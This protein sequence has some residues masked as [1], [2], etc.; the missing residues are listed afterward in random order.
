METVSGSQE[1][2]SK[3]ERVDTMPS[4][5][6]MRERFGMEA[7]FLVCKQPPPHSSAIV[8]GTGCSIISRNFSTR[9]WM[10][11]PSYPS[12]SLCSR[13][14]FPYLDANCSPAASAFGHTRQPLES[15][16]FSNLDFPPSESST[17]NVWQD[18]RQCV[19]SDHH[20]LNANRLS[21]VGS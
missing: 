1:K 13:I 16:H 7:W 12:I 9:R 2:I 5:R 8:L 3:W 20:N 19:T 18:S 17:D 21:I 6:Q 14:V 10:H 4:A 11:S 15:R